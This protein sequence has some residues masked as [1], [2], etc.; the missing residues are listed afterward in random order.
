MQFVV[1]GNRRLSQSNQHSCRFLEQNRG[2]F[3]GRNGANESRVFLLC[4]S[5]S[6]LLT[7]ITGRPPPPPRG[8]KKGGV[9]GICL[10]ESQSGCM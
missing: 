8:I 2:R 6:P 10:G 5:Q 7:E 1:K 9:G 4:Y 3:L